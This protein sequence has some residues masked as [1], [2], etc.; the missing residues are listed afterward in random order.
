MISQTDQFY[1]DKDRRLN[2]SIKLTKF[3]A[4]EWEKIF[5]FHPSFS[6]R[7]LKPPRLEFIEKSAITWRAVNDFT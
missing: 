2:L 5:I 4:A 3:I 7:T 6:V 1:T